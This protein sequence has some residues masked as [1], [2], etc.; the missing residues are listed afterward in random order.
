MGLG[1]VV[2]CFARCSG[3]GCSKGLG[4]TSNR[5]NRTRRDCQ[6]PWSFSSRLVNLLLGLLICDSFLSL[7]QPLSSGA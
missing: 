3:F 2:G 7:K 1:S 4:S 6:I 5:K